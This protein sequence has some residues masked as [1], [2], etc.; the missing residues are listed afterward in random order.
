MKRCI[1]IAKLGVALVAFTNGTAAL[2]VSNLPWQGRAHIPVAVET[3]G[4]VA[5]KVRVQ[6]LPRVPRR[7]PFEAGPLAETATGADG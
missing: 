1:H 5:L 7:E 2:A 4:G 3:A 6:R